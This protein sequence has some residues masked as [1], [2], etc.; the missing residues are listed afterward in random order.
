[1]LF[2]I[3]P[4]IWLALGAAL[5][6]TAPPTGRSRIV[7]GVLAALTSAVVFTAPVTAAVKTLWALG[8]ALVL[9]VRLGGRI[10]SRSPARVAGGA[11]AGVAVYIALGIAA[12][13]LADR[14]SG[15]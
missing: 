5:F 2:I 1:A 14:K 4:W 8:I 7:W 3:D 6:L 12:N 9:V 10:A 11:L 15:V 13:R